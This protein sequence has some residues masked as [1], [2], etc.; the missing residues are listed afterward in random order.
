MDFP[1]HGISQV[2]VFVIHAPLW[3]QMIEEAVIYL[4]KL[5][6]DFP[7]GINVKKII[8]IAKTSIIFFISKLNFNFILR[9]V[10]F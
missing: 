10:G 6:L 8:N 5:H 9:L 2:S 3:Q 1:F 7:N 4:I